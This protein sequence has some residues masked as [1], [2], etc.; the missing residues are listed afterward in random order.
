MEK[1]RLYKNVSCYNPLFVMVGDKE[2]EL[3]NILFFNDNGVIFEIGRGFFSDEKERVF[4]GETIK[5]IKLDFSCKKN[6]I[7]KTKKDY[8]S[9]EVRYDL[10]IREENADIEYLGEEQYFFG[11]IYKTYKVNG[12][13]E[14]K[15]VRTLKEK[16]N[17]LNDKAE[18]ILKSLSNEFGYN[19]YG[20]KEDI[21]D[22]K[23]TEL[24]NINKQ[25]LEE[26]N[27]IKNYKI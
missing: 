16:I 13:T 7:I 19:R 17:S 1:T 26:V 6:F 23:L 8:Y 3:D 5:K 14:R 24:K 27:S 21:L 9:T 12:S 2:Y 20:M 18:E 4:N 10:Y 22:E 15:Y 11:D 25:I